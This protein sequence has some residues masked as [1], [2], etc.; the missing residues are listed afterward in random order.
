VER[1][2]QKGFASIVVVGV[3]ILSIIVGLFYYKL[4]KDS[5]ELSDPPGWIGDQLEPALIDTTNWKTYA[6]TTY[7]YSFSYPSDWFIFIDIYGKEKSTVGLE[8]EDFIFLT[9][10][11]PC[12]TCGG[13]PRGLRISADQKDRQTT[14]EEYV[15]EE[16]LPNAEYGDNLRS[17]PAN[18]LGVDGTLVWGYV[19]AG[20]PGPELYAFGK[21]TMVNIYTECIENEIVDRIFQSIRFID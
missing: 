16:I 6:N 14:S 8:K 3:V 1:T 12:L 9:P 20:C 10:D 15:N 21:E 17:E 18:I 19:G 11:E 7:G 4:K 2:L 13:V 5:F